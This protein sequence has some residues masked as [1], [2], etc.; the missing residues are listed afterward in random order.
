[1][2]RA[3]V[4]A[5][6]L[7]VALALSLAACDSSGDA[8]PRATSGAETPAQTALDTQPARAT[9][10]APAVAITPTGDSAAAVEAVKAD[11]FDSFENVDVALIEVLSIEEREWTDSC[12]GAGL[13]NEVCAAVITPGYEIVVR[14]FENTYTYHTDATGA[15]LRLASLDI[16]SDS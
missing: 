9:A 10:T 4:V 13:P 16:F 5:A 2:P 12:L 14:Y 11:V 1:M 3:H 7:L 6:S 8:S 15:A